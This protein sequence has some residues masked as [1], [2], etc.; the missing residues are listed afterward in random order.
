MHR[1]CAL[2]LAVLGAGLGN[3]SVRAQSPDPIL[4]GLVESFDDV[5]EETLEKGKTVFGD[6]MKDMT[7]LNGKAIVAGDAFN[8][9]RGLDEKKFH[10]GVFPGFEFAW[11]QQK[12]PHLRPLMIAVYYNPHP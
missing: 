4:T 10:L 7:G 2:A 11:V 3:A 9:A 1:Y 12:H 8:V 6:L 5:P